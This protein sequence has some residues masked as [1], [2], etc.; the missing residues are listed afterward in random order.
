[1]AAEVRIGMRIVRDAHDDDGPTLGDLIAR[2]TR[3]SSVSD[4]SDAAEMIPAVL[5]RRRRRGLA[6][7]AGRDCI[8]EISRHG[9]SV[10]AS[11]TA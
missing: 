6:P 7:R 3:V 8:E 4:I 11:A 1:M 5:R 10:R 9:W 2:L